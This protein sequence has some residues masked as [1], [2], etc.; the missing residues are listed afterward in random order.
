MGC[1]FLLCLEEI[2]L[3]SL[4]YTLNPIKYSISTSFSMHPWQYHTF[5]WLYLKRTCWH[6]DEESNS[7]QDDEKSLQMEHE[8][9]LLPLPMAPPIWLLPPPH[10]VYCL[11]LRP[12]PWLRLEYWGTK[13]GIETGVLRLVRCRQQ[14]PA[15][16][17]GRESWLWPRNILHYLCRLYGVD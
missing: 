10:E 16:C 2:N 6:K 9:S 12:W 14:D 7:S 11:L 4:I 3:C 8:D 15:R 17:D 5:L 1:F 13:T